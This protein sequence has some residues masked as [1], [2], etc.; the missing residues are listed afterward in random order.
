[1]DLY[2]KQQH[3]VWVLLPVYGTPKSGT[4][5]FAPWTQIIAAQRVFGFIC[6]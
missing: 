1:M 3:F 5:T 2:L 4:L 6:Y